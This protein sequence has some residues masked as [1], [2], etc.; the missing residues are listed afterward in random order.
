M[1]ILCI[2]NDFGP[3]A[4]GIETFVIG[5]IERFP[6]K[7][8]IVYTSAQKNS[9]PYDRQW[10]ENFG[11]EVIRDRSSMLLP[12]PRV[13]RALRHI[14][15]S[16]EISQAWFGA[17]A[18]LALLAGGLRAHGVKRIIAL[19]HGHEVWWAK[20]PPFTLAMRYIGK[21]VDHLTYLGEFTQREISRALSKPAQSAMIKIAP[22]IDV[23]HFRPEDSTQLRTSLGIN[24]KKVIVSVGRL[25]P[26]KGQ[27]VLLK[28][29]P[30]IREVI[31]D[32]HVLMIGQGAYEKK[33]RAILQK[34]HCLDY[35]TF[36]GRIG[37]ED[38]PRY[39]SCGEVFVMPSRSRFFGL[40]VEGLGIVYLEASACGLPVVAGDSGGAP[41][42]VK[43]SITGFVVDGTSVSAVAS[44]TI[45]ILSNPELATSMG[46]AGRRW[47][48]EEWR[49]QI[50]SARFLELFK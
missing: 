24:E 39:L 23:D 26:R 47:I 48:E 20:I 28:A 25:V 27:D 42:A 21:N 35:V 12:T 2:T 4:G 37:Y 44:A 15:R 13:A 49:W 40:E 33:L 7:S 17:A 50:W 46:R 29:L 34:N 11:V 18:P 16:R 14:I 32:V 30:A 41:D 31:P 38:L 3:R 8:I 43:E 36:T 9:E 5:L 45:E 22:G 6:K 10:R 1:S 19:T